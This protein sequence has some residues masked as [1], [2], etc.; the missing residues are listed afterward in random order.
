MVPKQNEASKTGNGNDA[1]PA[2]PA[3]LIT[4]VDEKNPQP[5]VVPPVQPYVIIRPPPAKCLL[6]PLTDAEKGKKTL[7]LDLD[8]TL[9]HSSFKVR[10]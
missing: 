7:V 10:R 8:E 5:Q 9:V 2:P 4:Q 1:A 6:G 3:G